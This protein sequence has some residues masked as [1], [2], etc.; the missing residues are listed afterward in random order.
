[1]VQVGHTL[2]QLQEWLSQ[3]VDP[4]LL[5]SPSHR[6]LFKDVTE[7]DLTRESETQ[8]LRVF[9]Q[10]SLLSPAGVNMESYA[11]RKGSARISFDPK[12]RWCPDQAD[13]WKAER[14]EP[15]EQDPWWQRRATG[16]SFAWST[17]YV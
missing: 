15:G 12:G 13:T 10:K 17:H 9:F 7:F 3:S 6:D 8:N 11:P 5:I 2:P 1:M 16:S 4:T 14:G